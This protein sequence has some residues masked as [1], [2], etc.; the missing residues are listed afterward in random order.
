MEIRGIWSRETTRYGSVHIERP[1]DV[2][3]GSRF[4][5][6]PEPEFLVI[7]LGRRSRS[8]APAPFVEGSA[9]E[10]ETE[11]KMAA[12]DSPGFAYA[13]RVCDVSV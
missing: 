9:G 13:A 2:T 4:H 6:K 3:G 12:A 1:G 5:R 7:G 8:I 10:E 11:Q